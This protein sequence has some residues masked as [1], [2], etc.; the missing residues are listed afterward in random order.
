MSTPQPRPEATDEVTALARGLVVLQTVASHRGPLGH[1]ELS[2]L[3]GIPKTTMTRLLGTLVSH[4]M[5]LQEHDGERYSLGAGALDLGS[6]YLRHFDVRARIRPYLVELAEF[7]GA[8]VHLGVRDRFDMVLIDTIRPDTGMIFSRLDIGARLN[9]CTSA[10]GRAYLHELAPD[11]R[12]QLLESARIAAADE[13]A[14]WGS[15]VEA[16]LQEADRTGY[17]A[18]FG[19]WHPHVNS[20]AIGFTGPHGT[21]YAFNCGGPSFVFDRDTMLQRIGPRLVACRAA[22]VEKIG[23]TSLA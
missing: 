22:I 2:R 3:T 11:E 9:V 5:L 16:A 13:W 17:C 20:I 19:E 18:S 7:S 12:R 14:R 1:T 15:G 6:A 23:K 8:T 21:R 10:I 4:H